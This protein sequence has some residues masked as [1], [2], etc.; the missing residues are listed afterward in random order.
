[1]NR[2]PLHHLPEVAL[3]TFSERLAELRR[4]KGLTQQQL[5]ERVGLHQTQIH[6]YESGSS[7]PSMDA[8]RRLALALGVSTD[9]LVFEEAERGP[10]EE[11]RLQFEAVSRFGL[12]ENRVAKAVLDSLILQ[13]E[14][15]RWA[16]AS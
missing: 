5:A 9:A 8:L 6:R 12:E 13:H 7:E 15:R 3:M 4:E 16:A 10:D 2:S 1:M 11:L 14:A